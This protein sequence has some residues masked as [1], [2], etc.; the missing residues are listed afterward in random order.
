MWDVCD[1]SDFD[2]CCA[3]AGS[4]I[5]KPASAAPAARRDRKK[6][7]RGQKPPKGQK[8][9]S[10]WPPPVVGREWPFYAPTA[11]TVACPPESRLRA[12]MWQ[13]RDRSR[14]FQS[15][16]RVIRAPAAFGRN[17]GNVLVRVLDVAGFAV[18]AVWRV[19]D[20]T[21]RPRLLDPFVNRGRTIARRRAGIHV[22]LGGFLQ[23]RVSDAK[24]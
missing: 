6:T 10:A 2:A 1:A 3:A 15:H 16:V 7:G 24:M 4:V 18:D 17:P 11:R 8:G 13:H 19:D 21:W 23:S 20:K 12:T 14:R 22:M 5:M 9:P